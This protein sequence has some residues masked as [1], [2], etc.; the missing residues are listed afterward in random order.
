MKKFNFNDYDWYCDNCLA[1]LNNQNGFVVENGAWT[2]T[3]CGY[4]N[5]IDYDNTLTEH[6]HVQEY[7]AFVHCPNCDAHLIEDGNYM[8]CPDCQFRCNKE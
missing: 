1:H 7:L 5:K 4:I 3:N 6:S 8:I 2:C